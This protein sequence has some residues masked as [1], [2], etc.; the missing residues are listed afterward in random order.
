MPP[1]ALAGYRLDLNENP[2]S[3]LPSVREALVRALASANRYPEFL[4]R[5]LPELIADKVGCSPEHITVGPGATGV[6]MHLLQELVTPG[7]HVVMAAPTFEGYPLLTGTVGGQ[8]VSVPLTADG[9]QDLPAMAAAVGD[10]TRLIVVCSPHN[11]TGTIL[12]HREFDDFLSIIPPPITVLLDE[13]YRE[14]VTADERIDVATLMDR[15]PNLLVMR[16]FS[17]AFGLAA[18]RIGYALGPVETLARIR[19]WQVPFGMHALSD[20][21]VQACFHAEEEL[22]TRTAAITGE[23]I[24]LST[25]LGELGLSIPASSG[26]FVYLHV[27]EPESLTRLTRTFDRA[28][29]QVKHYP[30]G[31]RITIGDG[32]ATDAVIAAVVRGGANALGIPCRENTAWKTL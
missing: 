13:A 14:F 3:P 15:Y 9:H 2:Y 10:R 6:I 27:P 22:A 23:R 4:P 11:P 25:A 1:S 21:A 29:I 30:T 26:N 7:D 28:S 16:T 31:I 32:S 24:R 17:K 18:L 8:A 20:A 12:T 19:R 5:R